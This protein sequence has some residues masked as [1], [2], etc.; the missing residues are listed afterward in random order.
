MIHCQLSEIFARR[1]SIYALGALSEADTQ[2]VC[3]L[4]EQCLK[5][6]PSAFNSQSGRLLI[7]L[8]DHHQKLW[9]LTEQALLPLTPPEKLAAMQE[10]N[11]AFAAATGTVL[12]FEDQNTVTELQ[13]QYPLYRDSFPIWS[14]QSAG[15][16]QYMIWLALA[17][18]NIGASLQHY[19][20]LI[21]ADVQKNWQIPAE[22]K[23][24]AQMP[25]GRIEA[26]AGDKSF[27]PIKSRLKI[28]D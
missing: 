7:L 9:Q 15:M 1:R 2:N 22:W 25:F 26:P 10:R 23:L 28:F 13:R 4:A 19:N 24:L 6:C 8:R 21:D 27:A 17:N 3:K 16:L 20:P 14:M 12:F 18:K 11:R 5:N